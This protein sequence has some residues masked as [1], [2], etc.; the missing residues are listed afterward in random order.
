MQ[1]ITPKQFG[2]WTVEFLTHN[3]VSE[4]CLVLNVWTPEVSDKAGLPVV[5]FIPGGGFTSG[6]SDVAIYD[7]QISRPKAWWW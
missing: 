5:M 2:P 6:A 4:D 3:Q 1:R 7:G